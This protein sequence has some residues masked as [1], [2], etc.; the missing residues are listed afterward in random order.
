MCLSV[1]FYVSVC[2]FACRYAC[3]CVHMSVSLSVGLCVCLSVCLSVC[4][5][6]CLTCFGLG[7][8]RGEGVSGLHGV[9]GDAPLP[10]AFGFQHRSHATRRLAGLQPGVPR[11]HLIGLDRMA[12]D[13]DALWTLTVA[14]SSR[15]LLT[16]LLLLVHVG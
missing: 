6:A 14:H 16:L 11:S 2:L 12:P 13:A 7:L 9:D 10:L 15:L 5:S 4:A 3:L 8:Q 1:S